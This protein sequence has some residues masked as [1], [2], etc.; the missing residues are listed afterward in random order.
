MVKKYF[1]KEIMVAI[2]LIVGATISV[3]QYKKM[4]EDVVIQEVKE[5][6][7]E[8]VKPA[9]DIKETIETELQDMFIQDKESEGS[10]GR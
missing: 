8:V 10:N 3:N 6:I 1:I 9:E 2:L 4:S 5:S 7:K